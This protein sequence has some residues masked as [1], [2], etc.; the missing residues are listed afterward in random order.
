MSNTR[1]VNAGFGPIGLNKQQELIDSSS[2]THDADGRPVQILA[3]YGHTPETSDSVSTSELYHWNFMEIEL[4]PESNMP[5]MSLTIRN[6]I[7][8]PDEFPRGGNNINIKSMDTGRQPDSILPKISLIPQADVLISRLDGEP[9]R[10]TQTSLDG[11]INIT[12]LVGINPDTP[13]LITAYSNYNSISQIVNT[14]PISDSE[15]T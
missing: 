5:V 12:K 14:I 1:S 7:D 3:F 8:S 13:L 10:G 15:T 2:L 4:Q 11:T 6:I 9:V